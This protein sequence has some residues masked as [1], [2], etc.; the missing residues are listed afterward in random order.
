MDLSIFI[1]YYL[2]KDSDYQLSI[3]KIFL[4]KVQALV[5]IHE[6]IFV[7]DNFSRKLVSIKDLVPRKFKKLKLRDQRRSNE[8]A[9]ITSPFRQDLHFRFLKPNFWDTHLTERYG[10]PP[11]EQ[12]AIRWG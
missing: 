4:I 5:S 3:D 8:E 10:Q 1:K 6:S 11:S 9:Q 2:D 7:A 12:W